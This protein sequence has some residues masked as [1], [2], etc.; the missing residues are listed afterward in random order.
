MLK[1]IELNM[2]KHP[3]WL[4]ISTCRVFYFKEIEISLQK[5]EE[6]RKN[7][8][9]SSGIS[10]EFLSKVSQK[11]FGKRTIFSEAVMSICEYLYQRLK[12]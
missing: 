9:R 10:I 12:N 6:T 7:Q 2:K 4:A 3:Y 5:I 11:F 8:G 1:K